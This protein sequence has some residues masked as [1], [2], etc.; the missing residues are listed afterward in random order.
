M[1]ELAHTSRSILP[2]LSILVLT[3]VVGYCDAQGLAFASKS[4]RNSTFIPHVALVSLCY[5]LVAIFTHIYSI[6]MMQEL[7]IASSVLQSLIW[8]VSVSVVVTVATGGAVDWSWRERIAAANA[9]ISI[10][11]L[12]S[13]TST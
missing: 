8:L 9:I 7:G 4:W 11:W 13:R 12:I 10:G 3:I 6:K 5:F 2:Y 1:S